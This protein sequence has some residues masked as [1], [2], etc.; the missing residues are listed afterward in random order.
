[1]YKSW[2]VAVCGQI[3]ILT[4]VNS[5]VQFQSFTAFMTLVA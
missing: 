3:D 4:K 2:E 1:M 5:N